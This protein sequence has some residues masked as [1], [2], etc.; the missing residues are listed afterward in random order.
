MFVFVFVR[1]CVCASVCVCSGLTYITRE[2]MKSTTAKADE[3]CEGR[4]CLPPD[5]PH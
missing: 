2:G 4:I 3:S 5:L 1:L